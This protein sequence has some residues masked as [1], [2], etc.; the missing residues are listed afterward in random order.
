MAGDSPDQNLFDFINRLPERK[1]KGRRTGQVCSSAT[2]KSIRAESMAEVTKVLRPDSWTISIF[3]MLVVLYLVQLGSPDA[4]FSLSL[5]FL[6]LKDDSKSGAVVLLAAC[7]TVASLWLLL[8]V[9]NCVSEYCWAKSFGL[10]LKT[11][12][13]RT[14][15]GPYAHV[16][17]TAIFFSVLVPAGGVLFLSVYLHGDDFT[18]SLGEV[19]E[20]LRLGVL[21]VYWGLITYLQRHPPPH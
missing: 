6:E 9:F 4:I 17:Q 18:R 2:P 15:G 16:A 7:C 13:W 5:E 19:F 3:A 12:F 11:E 14:T 10:P 21:T 20:R 8:A 1:E